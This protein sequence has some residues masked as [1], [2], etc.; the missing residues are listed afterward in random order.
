MDVA[1]LSQDHYSNSTH[2][3][4][5]DMKRLGKKQELTRNFRLVSS[6]AF[7][8]CVMGTWEIL[9]TANTQGLIAGGLAGLFWSLCWTYTG[10]FFVVLS[11]AEMAS[12]FVF[13]VAAK[14]SC[15]RICV[16]RRLPADSI[17]T[18]S[19]STL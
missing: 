1:E 14:R 17:S 13:R 15:S 9:L 4:Q 12:M 16:G 19:I 11:L 18:A 10:Q 3:D 7:T 2:H 8:T 6:I 5:L